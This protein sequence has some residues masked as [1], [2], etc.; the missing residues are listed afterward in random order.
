MS[1]VLQFIEFVL[2]LLDLI[3][4]KDVSL[5]IKED[6]F[7]KLIQIS[8]EYDFIDE[9]QVKEIVNRDYE[10]DCHYQMITDQNLHLLKIKIIEHFE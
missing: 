6:G 5:L 4:S 2:S 10:F 1:A 9:N 7:V 3:E 8:A